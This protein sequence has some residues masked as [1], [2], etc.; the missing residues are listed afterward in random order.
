MRQGF[1]PNAV[2]ISP[3]SISDFK[4][5]PQAYFYHYVYRSPKSGLKIQVINPKLS[6][7]ATVHDTLHRFLYTQSVVKTHDQLINILNWYWRKVSG[8]KGGFAS[9][10]EE[11]EYKAKALKM[12]D[13]F[14]DNQHFQSTSPEKLPDFPKVNL[15]E[16]LILTGK[17]DW[18]EKLGEKLYR[19][20]DFKT[21]QR[22][23]KSDSLQLPIYAVIA[24]DYLKG[25]KIQA[26]YWYL[27]KENDLR[28]FMLPELDETIKKL[29]D[30]GRQIKAA[31]HTKSFECSSG[32]ESCWACRDLIAV[33]KGQGKLVSVNF[34]R[35][36]EIYII[37]VDE[38]KDHDEQFE[39]DLPF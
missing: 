26:S 27:G 2:F 34:A 12:L 31:R 36:Q 7:G 1:I 18:I 9:Q 25:A 22:E 37:P 15:G 11:A 10:K 21:G 8:E 16:E 20:V 39:D 14:W 4:A 29:K 24:S 33:S 3:S 30:M 38:T 19:I 32:R 13:R 17:L 6:L 28:E 23:E 35:K 5:C